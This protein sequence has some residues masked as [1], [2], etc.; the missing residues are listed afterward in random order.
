MLIDL[1]KENSFTLE[2]VRCR[3][4]PTQTITDTDYIDDIALLANSPAPGESLLHSLE[5]ATGG[6]GLHVNANKTEYM[7]FNQR[8]DISPL[9]S[10]ALKLVDMFTISDSAT[11]QQKMTS[12]CD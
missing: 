10:D 12:V 5:Q 9:Y 1:M 4:S 11:H 6:I 2:K 8:G 7:C 3:W